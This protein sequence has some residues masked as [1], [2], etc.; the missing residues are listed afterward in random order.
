MQ[1]DIGFANAHILSGTSSGIWRRR[2]NAL[3]TEQGKAL[4]GLILLEPLVTQFRR[5]S[6]TF[7]KQRFSDDAELGVSNPVIT[8][9]SEQD[10]HGLDFSDNNYLVAEQSDDSQC[11]RSTNNER[12]I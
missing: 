11:G 12:G 6:C 1:R 4:P 8:S 5:Q 10:T 7:S 9:A 3:E 2:I